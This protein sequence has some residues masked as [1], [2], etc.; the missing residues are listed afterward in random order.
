MSKM[1]EE[2]G[3]EQ[4]VS[5]DRNE[6]AVLSLREQRV[7]TEPL[8]FVGSKKDLEKHGFNHSEKEAFRQRTNESSSSSRSESSDDAKAKAKPD[9]PKEP[10]HSRI[11]PL[12]KRNPPPVPASRRISREK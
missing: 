12:K 7:D 8:N 4:A 9:R 10:W 3:L 5:H 2:K 6:E 1:G 11:N